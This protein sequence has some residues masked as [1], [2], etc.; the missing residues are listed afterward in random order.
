MIK[1]AF[2]PCPNDTFIFDAM[3]HGKIDTEGLVF[4]FSM[5]DVEELNRR[6][7]NEGA[8]MIKI[9]YHTYPDIFPNYALL[10]S[11]GAFGFGNGPVLVSRNE[12]TFHDVRNYKIA[13]PGEHTTAHL[14]FSIAFPASQRKYFMVYSKIEESVL[15]GETDAGVIIHEGR[16]TYEKKGLKKIMD[17]GEFWGKLTNTPVPLGCIVARKSLGQD[18]ID[19][20]NRV[21]RRSVEY[22]RANSED[23][24]PFVRQHALELERDVILKHI[25]FY[26][27]DLTVDLGDTGRSAVAALMKFGSK[28]PL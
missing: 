2:S 17:L 28:Q 5:A 20:L 10:D 27:N 16:F 19:K 7:L 9:S 1:L 12:I 3:V 21:M 22:A 23:V 13:L 24:M 25:S 26:V 8:D 14:L 6:V 15:K 11:G 18:T 4:E